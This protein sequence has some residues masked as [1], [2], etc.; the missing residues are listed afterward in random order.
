MARHYA[1][2]A[3]REEVPVSKVTI[4]RSRRRTVWSL[5]VIASEAKQSRVADDA[6]DRRGGKSRLAM[7]AAAEKSAK[8][9]AALDAT[10]A[11]AF[12]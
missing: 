1:P 4:G 6:L 10:A 5:L 8:A 3:M 9:Q 12:L 7:T 11:T 2:A